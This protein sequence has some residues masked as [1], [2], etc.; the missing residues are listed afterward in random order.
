MRDAGQILVRESL[1]DHGF[2]QRSHLICC[3]VAAEVHTTAVLSTA[4]RPV[5]RSLRVF[6]Q[7]LAPLIYPNIQVLYESIGGLTS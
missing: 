7:P 1:V 6:R 2:R 4:L 5:I 3:V